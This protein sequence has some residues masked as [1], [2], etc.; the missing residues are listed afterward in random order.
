MRGPMAEAPMT[1]E[2]QPGPFARAEA[3][4]RQVVLQ[5]GLGLVSFVLGG[6]LVA[7]LV[8]RLADRVEPI[9]HEWLAWGVGWLLQRLW[10]VAVLPA[11]AYGVGRFSGLALG[12]FT[13]TAALSGETFA[14]LLATAMDGFEVLV[15]EPREL[16]ARLV[17]LAVGMGVVYRAGLAG[18][19]EAAE[20]QAEA[21]AA[22]E[23]RKVEYAEFLAKA[24]G[25]APPEPPTG[26]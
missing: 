17:T 7:G 24:E 2:K 22:A 6:F 14:V 25:G 8:S 19:A 23:R 1:S 13:L 16:V 15:A 10:L 20:D 9:E 11:F 26:P 21:L 4:A 12:S 5:L 3:G 18:R